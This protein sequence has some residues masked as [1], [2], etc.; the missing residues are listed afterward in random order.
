MKRK[1][2][3]ISKGDKR[4]RRGSDEEYPTDVFDTEKKLDIE[5]DTCALCKQGHM[6]G[7]LLKRELESADKEDADEPERP[8]ADI[9]AVWISRYGMGS[10]K[11]GIFVHFW[12]AF[13]CPRAWFTPDRTWKGVHREVTRSSRLKCVDCHKMGA[14]IGCLVPSCKT[15]LHLPCAL[16]NGFKISRYSSNNFICRK[17]RSDM[18]RED[19]KKDD[20][21]PSDFTKGKEKIPIHCNNLIDELNPLQ[22][23]TY[24]TENVDSDDFALNARDVSDLPCCSC[25]DLCD[26]PKKCE[27]LKHHGQSYSLQ[28]GLLPSNRNSLIS[29]SSSANASSISLRKRVPGKIVECNLRCHCSFR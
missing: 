27:C 7:V 2:L 23:F 26:D 12:C 22:D 16:K 9:D 28:G 13:T 18:E 19:R 1:T 29:S 3:G 5:T 14:A 20:K 17:H 21:L 10:G 8:Q 11:K 25:T 24:I 15:S 4:A 6:F